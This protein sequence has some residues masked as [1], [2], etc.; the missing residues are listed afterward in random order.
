MPPHGWTLRAGDHRLLDTRKA[1]ILFVATHGLE[2]G[3]NVTKPHAISIAAKSEGMRRR[4][5]KHEP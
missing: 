1:Y 4:K 5:L 3:G 2:R